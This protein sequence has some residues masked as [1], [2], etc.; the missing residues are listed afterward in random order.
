M[1]PLPKDRTSKLKKSGYVAVK[2]L[3]SKDKCV[4]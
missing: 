1:N 2:T 4:R 3:F